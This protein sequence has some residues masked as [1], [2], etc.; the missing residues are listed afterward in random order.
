MSDS[1]KTDDAV[2]PFDYEGSIARLEEI[3]ALLESHD[4]RL[5]LALRLYEEGVELARSCMKRLRDA[6]LRITELRPADTD[7]E[8]D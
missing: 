8:E 4:T 5:D 3:V 1:A 2:E 7:T 6:E